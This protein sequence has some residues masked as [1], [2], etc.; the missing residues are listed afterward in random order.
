MSYRND[1]DLSRGYGYGRD[2]KALTICH[3]VYGLF[4]VALFT[5]GLSV[6]IGGIVAY[7]VRGQTSGTIYRSHIDYLISTFWVTMLVGAVGWTLVF[8]L[9]GWPILGLLWLWILYRVVKGWIRLND[10]RPM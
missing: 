8:V 2:R 10:D 9:I 6:L 5:A 3:I 7:I 1:A 4:G